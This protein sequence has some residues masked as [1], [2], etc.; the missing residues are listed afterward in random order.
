MS[1][2]SVRRSH[3]KC[4][5]ANHNYSCSCFS[6]IKPRVN[7][8]LCCTAVHGSSSSYD[9]HLPVCRHLGVNR[10]VSYALDQPLPGAVRGLHRDAGPRRRLHRILSHREFSLPHCARLRHR[11][12]QRLHHSPAV[13]NYARS[14]AAIGGVRSIGRTDSSRHYEEQ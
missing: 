8:V 6:M 13:E 14:Q 9:V 2:V 1:Q 4:S 3:S 5:V 11:R 7:C 12:A 10:S